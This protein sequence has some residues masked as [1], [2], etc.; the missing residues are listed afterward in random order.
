MKMKN[1]CAVLPDGSFRIFARMTAHYWD[2][3]SDQLGKVAEYTWH[4][5]AKGYGQAKP[6]RRTTIK[7]HRLILSPSADL[8]VDHMDGNV[9][10]NRVA[11]LRAVDRVTNSQNL[12]HTNGVVP[13]GRVGWRARI[14]VKDRAIYSKTF[15]CPER[16]KEAHLELKRKYHPGFLG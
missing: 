9:S 14:T 4:A 11:N 5:N 1:E 6:N 2:I 13:N 12:H 3:D 7:L 8:Q 10:N 15:R 16:A